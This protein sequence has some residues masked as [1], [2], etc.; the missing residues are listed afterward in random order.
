MA[1]V[2]TG[3]YRRQHHKKILKITSGQFGTRRAYSGAP[4]RPCSKASG[5]PT[6]TGAPAAR[7]A[8][9][10]DRPHQRRRVA[11]RHHLQPPDPC[12]E[13]LQDRPQPQDVGRPGSA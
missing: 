13:G 10:V 2:K 9:A 12:Y 4:M 5:I 7:S 6:A 11:E 3:P 8:P 1:R